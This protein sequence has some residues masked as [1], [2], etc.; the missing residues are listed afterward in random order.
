VS[1]EY[2]NFTTQQIGEI[3]IRTNIDD[4]LKS[5][6]SKTIELNTRVYQ[7]NI[8][9][10]NILLICGRNSINLYDKYFKLIKTINKIN[11]IA[12]KPYFVSTNEND[13]VFI[14]EMT[15]TRIIVTDLD[16]NFI[17]Y[18]QSSF[19]SSCYA[20]AFKDDYLYVCDFIDSKICRF[21]SDIEE[22]VYFKLDRPPWDIKILNNTACVGDGDQF[23]NYS[24][25]FYSLNDNSFSLLKRYD[26]LFGSTLA[27]NG[28]FYH[29]LNTSKI[30]YIYN[31]KG[32][33]LKRISTNAF[34]DIDR[35]IGGDIVYLNGNFLVSTINSRKIIVL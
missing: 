16:L 28:Y 9:P 29:L 13:R 27:Y 23:Q 6:R 18:S 12:I 32:E 10:N 7:M 33:F 2:G 17:K 8:L 5:K 15:N 20:S 3:W 11:N 30:F 25:S 24:F 19:L 21:E 35:S 1:F 31:D 22:R 14:S 26:R 34:D 4:Q